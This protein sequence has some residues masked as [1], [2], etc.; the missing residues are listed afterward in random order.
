MSSGVGR[1]CSSDLA[2]LCLWH[3]PAV[4]APIRPL[5]WETP[6]AMGTDL[7]EDKRQKKK[8]KKKKKD[9]VVDCQ[10]EY[11]ARVYQS[12]GRTLAHFQPHNLTIV[13]TKEKITQSSTG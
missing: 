6:Y 2:L 11:H 8:K 12:Q 1:I 5:A 10:T 4:T 13:V 3:R 9:A 7:K